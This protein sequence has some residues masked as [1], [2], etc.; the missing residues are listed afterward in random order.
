MSMSLAT[1]VQVTT[2]GNLADKTMLLTLDFNRFGNSRQADV[3]VANTTAQQNRFN[4]TKKLL[5]SPELKAIQKADNALRLWIDAQPA[6]WKHGK[7]TRIVGFDSVST[8][9]DA[10]DTYEKTTRPA[11]VQLFVDAY[12]G[13]VAEAQAALGD[14]FIASEYPTVEQVKAEFSFSWNLLSFSTPEKLKTISPKMFAK[15]QEKLSLAVDEW[16]QGRRAIL[17][18]MVKHLFEILKPE[19]GKKKKL[20]SS[21]VTKL[22]D[23]LTTY[24]LNSVPDDLELQSD[25]TKLK[26]LM[27]GVDTDKIK[28]SDNLKAALV[29]GF[30][31][32]G[33][34]LTL[35]VESGRK[36]R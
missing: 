16:K 33:K 23:F 9:V 18:G 22:Q 34:N 12:L 32:I 14:K 2:I 1:E 21:A 11:L 15:E 3:E 36:F 6:C 17:Q 4:H 8:I 25:V 30:A 10:C 20:Y 7:S 19:E 5:E 29:E 26:L 27:T 28:E 35:T 24:D 13:R 31:E